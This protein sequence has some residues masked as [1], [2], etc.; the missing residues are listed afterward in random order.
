MRWHTAKFM[1]IAIK[2]E[3]SVTMQTIWW[4]CILMDEITSSWWSGT[5]FLA[6]SS[7]SDKVASSSCQRDGQILLDIHDNFTYGWMNYIF[8]IFKY[9][10]T[11]RSD[12]VIVRV[13]EET[14]KSWANKMDMD[15]LPFLHQQQHNL[16]LPEKIISVM[17]SNN[18]TIPK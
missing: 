14:I 9:K 13:S 10:L 3:L 4:Y 7:S 5:S 12:D 1:L 18:H 8:L 11:S 15:M 16:C 17:L 2:T 6:N